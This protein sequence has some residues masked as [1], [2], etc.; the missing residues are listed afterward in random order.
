MAEGEK[1]ELPEAP[2]LD[3][4]SSVF[5]GIADLLK[6]YPRASGAQ[7]FI[8]TI[9]CLQEAVAIVLVAWGAFG[10]HPILSIVLFLLLTFVLL[11]LLGIFVRLEKSVAIPFRCRHVPIYPPA[12]EVRFAIKEALEEIRQDAHNAIAATVPHSTLRDLRVN[13]F[14]LAKI[15]GGQADGQWKLVIHD[16]F[17]INMDNPAEARIQFAI[18][19]GATGTS[20]RDGTYQLSRRQH[21]GTG[22]WDHRHH[23]THELDRLVEPRLKWIVSFPLLMPGTT[24][25]AVGVLNIDGLAAVESDD[26]LNKMANSIKSKIND[27][28]ETLSLQPSTCV[29]IDQLGVIAH[30]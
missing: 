28:A 27:I 11:G 10:P 29:G 25:E 18:G 20:Y 7:K 22:H 23:M 26:V 24:S 14:L 1:P 8:I 2:D 16:D 21:T 17:A 5:S 4:L 3:D 13:V 12:P 30:V 9:A 19:Q 15:Q 6:L